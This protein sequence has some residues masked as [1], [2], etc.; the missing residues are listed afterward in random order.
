MAHFYL[1]DLALAPVGEF[2]RKG[3][4]MDWP[5]KVVGA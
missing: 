2:G 4:S 1:P 5:M 3:K